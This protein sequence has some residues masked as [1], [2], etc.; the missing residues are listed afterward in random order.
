MGLI[1]VKSMEQII[2]DKMNL[3][4]IHYSVHLY[5]NQT[6]IKIYIVKKK[7]NSI[8]QLPIYMYLSI[9][10]ILCRLE[11]HYTWCLPNGIESIK[12][13]SALCST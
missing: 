12:H 11:Q 4:K 5:A 13:D 10:D 7:I 9:F 1:Y 3:F 6:S 8:L 2:F